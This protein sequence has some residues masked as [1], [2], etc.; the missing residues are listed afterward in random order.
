M[1]LHN[2]CS[3]CSD[4][5]LFS[6]T[7]TREL[8]RDFF[9]E[10]PPFPLPKN[11]KGKGRAPTS[12]QHQCDRSVSSCSLQ[13]PAGD[14]LSPAEQP[15]S[16]DSG[17]SHRRW[18]SGVTTVATTRPGTAESAA[19][20]MATAAMVYPSA[21]TTAFF[22]GFPAFA[23][24]SLH[25]LFSEDEAAQNRKALFP[26]SRELYLHPA[27]LYSPP[28]I[29]EAAS[30]AAAGGPTY[31]NEASDAL[32]PPSPSISLPPI[33][34][35]D[36]IEA[37]LFKQFPPPPPPSREGQPVRSNALEDIP[38]PPLRPHHTQHPHQATLPPVC[39]GPFEI[40]AVANERLLE[41]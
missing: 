35:V 21:T 17:N 36:E 11:R 18:I 14:R 24:K 38:V 20:D 6:F 7:R 25:Y 34:T 40:P 22:A 4:P 28:S 5:F 33:L 16:P 29:K 32:E 30:I 27:Q 12:R 2:L 26:Q 1:L 19:V 41:A 15:D 3:S 9:I 37:A 8:K 31:G 13:Q 23:T 39:F 10:T